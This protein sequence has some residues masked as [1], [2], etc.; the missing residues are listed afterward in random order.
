MC[1]RGARG[2]RGTGGWLAETKLVAH[3]LL[4]ESG[5]SLVLVDTGFGSGDCDD[6]GRLGQ[7]FRALIRPIC[8]VGET[9][10]RRVRALGFDP[11][12]VRDIVVT[13]LDLDHAG[14]LG[15]FPAARVHVFAPELDAALAPSLRERS[16]YL[17]AQWAHHPTWVPHR[18]EGDDW[19]GFESVRVLPDLEA[20]VALVPLVGHT[21]G[22]TGVAVSGGDGWLMHCGDAFFHRDEVATPHSCPPVLAAFQ[23]LT[24][25]DG[26]AR[27]HNQERLRELGR[28]HGDEVDLICSH[29]PA[30]LSGAAGTA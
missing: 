19:F 3:C 21:R 30:L 22:H 11:A 25:Y 4:I 6:P 12:D 9:A 2:L 26:R 13:H 20:E 5:G 29:D 23:A 16:R 1:P 24:G 7:P 10:E 14:G 8:D 18:T 17:P 15:D 27:R 28:R